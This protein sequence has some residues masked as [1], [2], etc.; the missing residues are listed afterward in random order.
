MA[1]AAVAAPGTAWADMPCPEDPRESRSGV[2]ANP[3]SPPVPTFASYTVTRSSAPEGERST[4]AHDVTLTGGDANDG[5]M[6]VD[7]TLSSDLP[8][9]CPTAVWIVD[10]AVSP[11][12]QLR[13]GGEVGKVFRFADSE[14]VQTMADNRV[15]PFVARLKGDGTNRLVLRLRTLGQYGDHTAR[16]ALMIRAGGQ[17]RYYPFTLTRLR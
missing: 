11:A 9:N 6:R 5:E 1:V 7:I 13:G 17:D 15:F 14:R 3:D 16:L 10:P 2:I 12:D 4:G 8:R